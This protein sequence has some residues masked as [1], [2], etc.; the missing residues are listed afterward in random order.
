MSPTFTR[1][2][3]ALRTEAIASFERSS[4]KG[5]LPDSY[6][7]FLLRTNGGAPTPDVIDVPTLRGSPTDVALFFGLNRLDPSE[8]IPWNLA[9]F[10]AG[11]PEEENAI[12]IARDGG[13]GLFCLELRGHHAVRYFEPFILDESHYVSADFEA[14][15]CALRMFE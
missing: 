6:R 1:L 9:V 11:R 4:G 2:G 8:T 7:H 13:G 3:P 14:F 10:Q 5:R 15:L 12:P